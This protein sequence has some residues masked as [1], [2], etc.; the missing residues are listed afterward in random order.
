MACHHSFIL[1][2]SYVYESGFD[3]LPLKMN[4]FLLISSKRIAIVVVVLCLSGAVVAA[5]E[6]E[7]RPSSHASDGPSLQIDETIH[8]F[9]VIS[10]QE[11]CEHSFAL[12]NVGNADLKIKKVVASCTCVLTKD[13]PEVIAAGETAE[14]RVSFKGKPEE[15]KYNQSVEVQTND[16]ANP[17]VTLKIVGEVATQ[18]YVYPNELILNDLTGDEDVDVFLEVHSDVWDGFKVVNVSSS[19]DGVNFVTR[20][21][22]G[23]EIDVRGSRSG[24][25][26]DVNIDKEAIRK[27]VYEDIYLEVESEESVG[28]I[29]TF[30]VPLSLRMRGAIKL[31]GKG[32]NANGRIDM[33][34][35]NTSIDDQRAY[36]FRVSD[37][38]GQLEVVRKRVEPSFLQVDL[39]HYRTAERTT[40]YRLKVTVPAGKLE[41]PYTGPSAGL[42]HL[43]FNHPRIKDF[44]IGIE[45]V[46]DTPYKPR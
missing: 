8:D 42:I 11:V 45:L 46:P 27:N 43:D 14:I 35:V 31:T 40:L 1:Y 7:S 5:A 6:L 23:S 37:T 12:K 34:R 4:N 41:R 21:L 25:H 13:V 20:E 3:L 17:L 22:V 28:G 26:I 19:L 44:D 39:E 9:G 15:N 18:L 38:D 30:K 36:L 10:L 29:K 33:N 24:W 32:V 2:L 16:P